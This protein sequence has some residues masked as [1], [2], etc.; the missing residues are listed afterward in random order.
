MGLPILIV[1]M[2]I[3]FALAVYGALLLV[4]I[5]K[6]YLRVRK[7]TLMRTYE[8]LLYSALNEVDGAGAISFIPDG[9]DE[10]I[11]D[12]VLVRMGENLSGELKEKVKELYDRLGYFQERVQELESG[13]KKK[14][15]SAAE[16]LGKIG[17][18]RAAPFLQPLKG[19][20]HPELRKAA[21]IALARIEGT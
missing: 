18:P 12:E 4:R 17:D 9:A 14:R 2:L 3:L 15:V 21:T 6:A 19:S 20:E 16:K 10:D 13:S 5:F 8:T 7:L 1:L 11:L